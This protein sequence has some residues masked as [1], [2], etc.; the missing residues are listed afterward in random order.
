MTGS[1]DPRWRGSYGIDAPYWAAAFAVVIA[2]NIVNAVLSG[3][4]WPFVPVVFLL[5]CAGSLP[6]HHAPRQVRGLG[7]PARPVGPAG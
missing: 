7:R 1:A 3:G 5:A 2:A 6:L 4:V